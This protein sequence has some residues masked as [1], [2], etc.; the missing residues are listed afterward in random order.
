[1]LK[2]LPVA[3]EEY[4]KDAVQVNFLAAGVKALYDIRV[5][6]FRSSSLVLVLLSF[7]PKP[8]AYHLG[9]SV[10]ES[11]LLAR[12]V[13]DI[14]N[15]RSLVYVHEFRRPCG[16]VH[17]LLSRQLWLSIPEM[18]FGHRDHNSN[19]PAVEWSGNLMYPSC[20]QDFH[21]SFNL[22]CF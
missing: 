18:A 9:R 20:H 1:M 3:A 22:F 10:V 14:H 12:D 8:L 19:C 16:H 13:H 6:C 21:V 17:L 2:Y 15:F 7:L 11:R 5:L 4:P